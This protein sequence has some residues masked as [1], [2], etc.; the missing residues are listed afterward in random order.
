MDSAAMNAATEVSGMER[1]KPLSLD[2]S[3]TPV[4]LITPPATKNRAALYNA[5][6]SMNT[7]RANIPPS[8]PMPASSTSRPREATVECAS[9]S[10]SATD[11]TMFTTASRAVAAPATSSTAE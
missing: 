9:S 2:S 7:T 3:V 4:A 6:A 5:W 10:F 1:R 11:R 8:P